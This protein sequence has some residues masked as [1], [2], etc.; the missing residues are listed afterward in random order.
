M[1]LCTSRCGSAART[2]PLPALIHGRDAVSGRD[3]LPYLRRHRDL[4]VALDADQR[5]EAEAFCAVAREGLAA[6]QAIR[7]GD[8]EVYAS[9]MQPAVADLFPLPASLVMPSYT[10][11]QMR[12][13]A[14][15]AGAAS[16]EVGAA[17]GGRPRARLTRSLRRRR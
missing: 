10:R 2:G 4:D 8:D 11:R 13:A 12:A 6:A 3:L 9:F 14:A 5:A 17:A 1:A 15:A 16:V 7:W